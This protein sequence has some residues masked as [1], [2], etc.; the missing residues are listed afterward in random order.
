MYSAI[1]STAKAIPLFV[2]A[3]GGLCPSYST[4]GLNGGP[5]RDRVE[6]DK[7]CFKKISNILAPLPGI[8]VN[9]TGRRNTR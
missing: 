1:N 3:E 4:I 8:L 9:R 7:I 2:R 5:F 6:Y